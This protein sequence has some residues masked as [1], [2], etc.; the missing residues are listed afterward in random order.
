MLT[1]WRN[2]FR[3][4]PFKASLNNTVLSCVMHYFNLH[5]INPSTLFQVVCRQLGLSFVQASLQTDVFRGNNTSATSHNVLSG[6][7][8][9][10]NEENLDQ[11][12]HD[13]TNFCP[14]NYSRDVLKWDSANLE[15]FWPTLH[16]GKYGKYCALSKKYHIILFLSIFLSFEFFE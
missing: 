2:L 9:L 11:C 13:P 5:R 16:S 10:G 4:Q 6:V 15:F 3:H 14:G 7:A 1:I 8:C 12:S